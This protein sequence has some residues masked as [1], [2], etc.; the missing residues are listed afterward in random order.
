MYVFMYAY[1]Y[2][3]T[4]ICVYVH[5]HICVCACEPM[6]VRAYVCRYECMYSLFVS[7]HLPLHSCN[8]CV[9]EVFCMPRRETPKKHTSQKIEG[10]GAGGS[11]PFFVPRKSSR[12]LDVLMSGRQ[13]IQKCEGPPI[14][15]VPRLGSP[16]KRHASKRSMEC[17]ETRVLKRI[18]DVPG[19][20]ISQFML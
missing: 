8:L 3:C 12:N 17:P 16:P 4:Y 15:S 1:M 5:M 7:T 18:Q 9:W 13:T 2:E 19:L 10:C 6:H 11:P 20:V 14:K